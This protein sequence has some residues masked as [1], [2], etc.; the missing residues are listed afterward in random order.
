MTLSLHTPAFYEIR[1][2]QSSKKHTQTSAIL[3]RALGHFPASCEK[4]RR[5]VGKRQKME[6]YHRFRQT[7]SKVL[8]SYQRPD[9][10]PRDPRNR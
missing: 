7:C 10:R 2:G 5:P 1:N 9:S 3:S 8:Y 4:W 6:E